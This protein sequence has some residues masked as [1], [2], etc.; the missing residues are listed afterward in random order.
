[1]AG[2]ISNLGSFRIGTPR[3]PNLP[4][5]GGIFGSTWP[6]SITDVDH[7]YNIFGDFFPESMT[8]NKSAEYGENTTLN[9][10]K[11]ILQ[12]SSG[13]LTTISFNALLF[14]RHFLDDLNERFYAMMALTER[15]DDLKRPP[16]CFFEAGPISM[17]CVVNSVGGVKVSEVRNDGTFRSIEFA[18]SLTEYIPFS[19]EGIQESRPGTPEQSTLYRKAKQGDTFE[20]VAKDVY[21]DPLKGI[22][23]RSVN[24]FKV[25]EE[26]EAGEELKL[27]PATHSQI[28]KAVAPVSA[29]ISGGA[30]PIKKLFETR[31]G[32]A[33]NY[34]YR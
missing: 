21:G 28:A 32:K 2:P 14:A 16:V 18:V 30:S 12:Y 5:I 22:H 17:Q 33:I 10:G 27:L 26:L 25:G 1:M 19:I 9:R 29:Q 15:D 31:G 11:P 3:L 13:K 7:D 23:I 20:S 8:I 6:W 24:T 4:I 34:S